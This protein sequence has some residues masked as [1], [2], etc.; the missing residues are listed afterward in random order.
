MNTILN[1]IELLRQTLIKWNVAPLSVVAFLCWCMWT[2]TEHYKTIACTIDPTSQGAL[3]VYLAAIA[4]LLY[5]MFNS[6]QRDRKQSEE[7]E[8]E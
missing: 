8:D 2:L 6:M 7:N 5:K 4:G 1:V 3:F